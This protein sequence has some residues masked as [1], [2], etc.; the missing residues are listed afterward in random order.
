M[1]K[2]QETSQSKQG[3]E[4]ERESVCEGDR[5]GQNKTVKCNSLRID[6]ALDY[7]K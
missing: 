6:C 2:E 5:E 4:R 1:N 3:R 7:D